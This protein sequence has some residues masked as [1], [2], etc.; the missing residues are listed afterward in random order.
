MTE[1]QVYKKLEK[2][3]NMINED[4]Y[5]EI[6]DTILANIDESS[7]ELYIDPFFLAEEL[8][9]ADGTKA[10][11]KCVSELLMEIYEDEFSN[12]NADAACNIGSLYYTGRTGEQ[13]YKKAMEYYT[14][15]ADGGSRQAQENLG[16]CYYY[17]RDTAV[18]YEKAF[19][20]FALGAFDGHLR[21]LY[22]IGD[23]Y[24]NGYYV[25]KNENEAF[26][27]YERCLRE[28]TEVAEPLVGADIM[29]R[30][31]DCYFKG[32]GTEK[33]YLCALEYYQKAE[34]LFYRRL[35]DGDFLIKGCYE[36]V[37]ARQAEVREELKKDLPSYKWTN[38]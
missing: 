14:A 36:S 24:R 19:N 28:M 16:Y 11:P 15:A 6:Y 2:I 29:M 12:G 3:L 17:G 18:D 20:Y 4:E 10:L 34:Q 23:M 13:S 31:A 27:I 38:K 5:P 25:K 37:I 22:K 26:L 35:Q 8:H 33:D 9:E 32:I 7:Q 1:K 30:I 21:S